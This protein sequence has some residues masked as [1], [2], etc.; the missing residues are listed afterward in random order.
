MKH[1]STYIRL[2][3]LQLL[4]GR[5]RQAPLRQREQHLRRSV[6][7]HDDGVVVT[8]AEPGT[9]LLNIVQAL[10]WAAPA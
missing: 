6:H 1:I 10:R 9:D 8:G 3:R 5:R 4:V 7:R 2:L